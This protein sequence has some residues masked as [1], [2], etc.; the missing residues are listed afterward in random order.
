MTVACGD[1]S[2]CGK[3]Y[4]KVRPC[5][6]CGAE[7]DFEADAL[8]PA[9]GRPISDGDRELAAAEYRRLKQAEKRQLFSNM[10]RHAVP[11]ATY[12]ESR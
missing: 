12:R 9:C 8:C 10:K 3:C 2:T 5:P 7:L 1:C 11:H 4:P 6:G